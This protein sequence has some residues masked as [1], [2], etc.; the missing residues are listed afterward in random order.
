M[1]IKIKNVTC[2]ANIKYKKYYTRSTCYCISYVSTFIRYW[3]FSNFG[4]YASW[5]NDKN[6]V[7]RLLDAFG[8]QQCSP[9][10]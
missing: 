1:D 3:K 2:G 5:I 4:R 7:I 6:N 9:F 10:H 8:V